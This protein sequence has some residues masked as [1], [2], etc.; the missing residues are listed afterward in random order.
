MQVGE[1]ETW[2]KWSSGMA[3][4]IQILHQQLLVSADS[5]HTGGGEGPIHSGVV[6]EHPIRGLFSIQNK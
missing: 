3:P 6:L 5:A 1:Y 4:S 2:S